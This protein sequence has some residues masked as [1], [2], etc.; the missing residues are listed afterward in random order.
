[1]MTESAANMVNRLDCSEREVLERCHLG[2][3]GEEAVVSEA[4]ASWVIRR[5]VE[6]LNW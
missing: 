4:E 6:L 3:T 2:L 5:L 1:M